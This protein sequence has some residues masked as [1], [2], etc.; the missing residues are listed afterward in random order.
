MDRRHFLGAF[1]ASLSAYS[2]ATRAQGESDNL[3]RIVT[4]SPAGTPGDVLGRALSGPLGRLLGRAVIVENR[5]GAIGTIALASVARSKPDGT[6]IGIL[7]LLTTVAPHLLAKP[8]ADPL[9][10]VL[11][12]RQLASWGNV[13]VVQADGPYRTLDQF[14][15]A[16]KAGT[17]AYASGGNG[18]PAHL[19]A[20]LF[21]QA[22]G[23]QLQHVPFTGAVAGV[24]AVVGGHVAMMF[25]TTSAVLGPL[26]AGR[27]R[28][29]AVSTPRRM[30]A[31]PEV[32][33]LAELGHPDV[34]FSDWLGLAVPLTTPIEVQSK[35][36][37]AV[38]GA[39]ATP[40]VQAR[41]ATLGFEAPMTNDRAGF[42]ALVREESARWQAVIR[43]AGV[44]VE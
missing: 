15:T 9:H 1:A 27:L 24:N 23:L 6:T 30:P 31:L 21:R 40:E 14:L 25:A 34:S 32:P 39:L 26:S 37:A 35:L 44:R 19:A 16:A 33:S 20:E 3:T 10:D 17:V 12:L 2:Q 42:D 18:T 41:L 7:S 28:A 5:P 43:R 38:S 8:A 13:L 4:G 22:L 36:V 11:P 29:L